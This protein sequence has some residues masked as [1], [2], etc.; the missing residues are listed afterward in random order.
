MSNTFLENLVNQKRKNL[1]EEGVT[2]FKVG[3]KN[4][5][6]IGEYI[7]ALSNTAALENIS[8]AFLIWGID[9]TTHEIVGTDFRPFKE[10]IGNE[11][12]ISWLSRLLNPRVFFKFE[13]LEMNQKHV[14]VLQIDKA[15]STPIAFKHEEY[16]RV[17]TY[18]KKLKE[19]P[20]YE[21]RLWRTFMNDPFERRTAKVVSSVSEVLSSLDYLS[22]FKLLDQRVPANLSNVVSALES[23]QLIRNGSAGM[24]EIT[25]LG[26]ILFANNLNDFENLSRKATRVIL[27]EG[28]N[29][30]RTIHEQ[31]GGKGYAS[32]FEGLINYINSLL[33]RNEIIETAFRKE[34]RMYPEIAVRELVANALI[35]QNFDI[36][37]TGPVIEIFNN[38]M[39]ITNPGLPLVNIERLLDSPP[40]SL[41]EKLA[42][43]MRRMGICEER[44]SGI[45]KVVSATEDYQLPAPAFY[46][47]EEHTKVTLFSHKSFND[48]TNDEKINAIYFHACLKYV[49]QDFLTNAS[50]RERFKLEDNKKSVISR[51]IKEAV[52]KGKIKPENPETSPK[53]MRYIPYWA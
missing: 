46:L 6:M 34:V 16:I 2:E 27:Y 39:E 40:R 13:E 8:Q 43:L 23:D 20:E 22:Y 41:N 49:E 21:K 18:K 48:M 53:Y 25:N 4:P 42:S 44:G 5:E 7:S 24:W 26:A 52:E 14:V 33:P 51:I 38:R 12:L 9:D 29:K 17:G 45:D 19:Y 31:I 1:N 15:H 50:L 36:R 35:H 47:Y 37:G 11:E 28:P 32:G 10:K 3:N 30:I